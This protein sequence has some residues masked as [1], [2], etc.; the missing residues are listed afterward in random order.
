MDY[1]DYYKIL[2]VNEKASKEEI[3][4]TYRKLAMK[5]HPDKNPGDKQAEERFKEIN[6]ANE[7]LSDTEKR[8][9][10]DQLSTSYASWQQA[11]GQPGAYRWEDLYGSTAAGG[12]RTTHV[13]FGDLGDLFG[14]GGGFSDF[15]RTFFSGGTAGQ[16]R[17]GT[18]TRR[19]TPNYPQPPRS[20]QQIVSISLYEAFHGTTRRLEVDGKKREIKIPPGVKNGTKVRA[21]GAGP[22]GTRGQKS[23]IYLVVQVSSDPQYDRM[24]NDIYTRHVVDIFTALLGGQIKLETISGDVLMKIPAGTQPGQTFRLAGKGMPVLRKKNEFGDLFVKVNIS[25]P[26]KLTKEQTDL[27]KKLKETGF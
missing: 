25:L 21:A 23:D 27:I 22:A 1:K 6:E 19:T 11:G 4:K 15:F 16:T 9:K 10:Y 20:Y 8:A 13:D 2:G 3:K 14:E 18:A 17:Q 26:K 7:V 5:Y 24:G 12:T